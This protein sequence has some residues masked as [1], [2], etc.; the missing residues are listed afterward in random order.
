MGTVISGASRN[1]ALVGLTLV[2][3]TNAKGI[4]RRFR[5]RFRLRLRHR[6]LR[7]GALKRKR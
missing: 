1:A 7:A 5:I 3:R 6:S 2:L 4:Y